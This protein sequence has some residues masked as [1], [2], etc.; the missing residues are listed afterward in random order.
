MNNNANIT[1][2]YNLFI[3]LVTKLYWLDKFIYYR[4]L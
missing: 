1:Y 2:S 4:L 3:Y